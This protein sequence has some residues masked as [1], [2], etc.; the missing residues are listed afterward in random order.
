MRSPT[1]R[2]CLGCR[3]SG[4]LNMS[5]SLRERATAGDLGTSLL[6]NTHGITPFSMLWLM[7]EMERRCGK[8]FLQL[9]SL[10]GWPLH[11]QGPSE[12]LHRLC[13]HEQQ[14]R[15][16]CRSKW[17]SCNQSTV[18][19]HSSYCSQ[20]LLLRSFLTWASWGC[21]CWASNKAVNDSSTS[22]EMMDWSTQKQNDQGLGTSQA[23]QQPICTAPRPEPRCH[24]LALWPP[25]PLMGHW[26]SDSPKWDHGWQN[27][28]GWQ[29]RRCKLLDSDVKLRASKAGQ[30]IFPVRFSYFCIPHWHAASDTPASS[31]LSEHQ[32]S[33]R[34]FW[35]K[36]W[37]LWNENQFHLH[38]TGTN[39]AFTTQTITS[40][41]EGN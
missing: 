17:N 39:V 12:M 40:V 15:A 30:S 1:K 8:M 16:C 24:H 41:G 6:A 19:P 36:L 2:G 22:R 31:C 37:N 28:A 5:G 18:S 7:H 11:P 9:L 14:N 34:K 33:S 4:W 13:W 3:D 21:C 38:F 27:Q 23:M 20:R 29:S 10:H 35:G 25:N 32:Q 26:V